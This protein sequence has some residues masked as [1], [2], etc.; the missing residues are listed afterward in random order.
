M[1]TY[2][3]KYDTAG[4]QTEKV[5]VINGVNK[6]KTT[7]TYDKLNR[8]KTVTEPNGRVTEYT[9]D[10]SGN[11]ETETIRYNGETIV[12][13]YENNEQNRLIQVVTRVNGSV[14][15]TTVYTYDNN[16]NQ[17]AATT[18]GSNV[19]SNTY[20]EKNQLI[21]TVAGGKTVINIYNGEGLRVAKSVNGSLTRYLYE[22]TTW[23]FKF[24]FLKYL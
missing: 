8:L 16:G 24:L 14:T 19:Q 1:D 2:T 5:E 9:Y 12:N 3:Y 23:S 11:R 7:Y 4:N 15:E 20:D 21:K 22:E 10:A 17:L 13:T 6:G 18:N